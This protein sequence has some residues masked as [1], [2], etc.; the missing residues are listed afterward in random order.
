[1]NER[2]GPFVAFFTA[3]FADT[4]H[5]LTQVL[6]QG[7]FEPLGWR[8]LNILQ[9]A[10]PMPTSQEMHK[11]VATRPMVQ[12]KLFLHLD[13]IS[14]QNLLCTRRAFLG[15][16]KYDPCSRWANEPAVEDDFASSGDFGVSAFMRSL[17]KA[18]EAQGRGFAHG[19]EKHHSEP[20]VKA[21]DLIQLC[22]GSNGCGA[23]EHEHSKDEALTSWMDGHRKACL[24]DAATKQY[25]SAVESA[26]QF[27]CPELREVFTAEEKK[28]CKL[29]GGIDEDGTV[30]TKC[31]LQCHCMCCA[32]EHKLLL[33]VVP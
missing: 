9:D 10:P 19:H 3:N 20:R 22:L 23:T 11:I 17:I 32:R 16:Q 2:F 8:P 1:M 27:G 26:R 25:D 7:A 13:A 28:R 12:A 4:Y 18:L 31:Q 29:D 21:I 14:H 30:W 5:V 33:R 6:A 15:K 24:R